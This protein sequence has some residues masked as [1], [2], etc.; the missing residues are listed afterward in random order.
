M[1]IL[2]LFPLAVELNVATMA[3][4]YTGAKAGDAVVTMGG[5]QYRLLTLTSSGTLTLE[6][7]VNADVCVVG[8]GANGGGRTSPSSGKTAGGDGGAGA[9]LSNLYSANIPACVTVV[10][11]AAQG[12]SSI[13]DILSVA[14]VSGSSGGSGGGQ[15]GYLTTAVGI[16]DGSSKYPFG[17]TTYFLDN[18]HCG[19]GGGGAGE[20]YRY[21]GGSSY[22]G[23]SNGG[24]GGTNGGNGATC[25]NESDYSYSSGGNGGA[26]GGGQGGENLYENQTAATP[27]TYYGSG[28]GGEGCGNRGI[29]SGYQGVVYIRIPIH[30][31]NDN[32]KG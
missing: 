11:G 6:D 22:S 10:I 18:P 24:S 2:N 16:G 25:F 17:N 3:I 5:V 27:A 8:G 14:A 29:G 26:R 19:G 28:G 31:Q 32:L 13:E 21:V 20:Y 4:G 30:N 1:S 23:A 12:A 15:G 7:A 9:K